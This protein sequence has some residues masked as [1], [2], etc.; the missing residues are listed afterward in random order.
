[1]GCVG[2]ILGPVFH[3]GYLDADGQDVGR[4]E[5]FADRQAAEAWLGDA[6]P[7]LLSR[8]VERVALFEGDREL[9]RMGLREE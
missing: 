3:W 9:Y 6:W 2:P 8:G 1:M 4:S 7:D 5:P